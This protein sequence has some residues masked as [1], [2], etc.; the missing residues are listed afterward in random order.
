MMLSFHTAGQHSV[1]STG[2][3]G[4]VIIAAIFCIGALMLPMT[5]DEASSFPSYLFLSV[6]QKLIAAYIL[7]RYGIC[8]LFKC[9]VI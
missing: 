9:C 6:H 4:I 7:G 1:A 3:S 8:L 2:P 5:G